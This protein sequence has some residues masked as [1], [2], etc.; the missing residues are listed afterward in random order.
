MENKET[1]FPEGFIFK[2]PRAGAPD[3]VKGAMSIKVDEFIPFLQEHAN[4]GWVNLDLLTSQ[5]TGEDGKPKLY[6]KLNT[7]KP[8]KKDDSQP[9]KLAGYNDI[10][11]NPETGEEIPF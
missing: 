10:V 9:A 7:W 4:N 11:V 2:R 8:E 5:K 1:V 3:F 6:C